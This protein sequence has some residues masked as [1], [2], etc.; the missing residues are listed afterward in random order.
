MSVMV[1]G[2]RGFLG[3]HAVLALAH[4][5]LDVTVGPPRSELNLETAPMPQIVAI[6]RQAGARTIVNA[7]GRVT[8][9]AAELDAGNAGVVRR[10]IEACRELGPGARLVHLGSAAEYGP[11]DE[12]LN[13]TSPPAPVTA[14]GISK[15]E[16]TRHLLEASGRGDVDGVVLRVFNPLG[17]GQPAGTLPGAVAAQLAADLDSDIHVAPLTAWRDFV[18]ARDVGRAIAAAVSADVVQER[19][20]NIASGR[21]TAVRQAIELMRTRAGHRGR[22]VEGPSVPGPG[23]AIPPWSAA[24]ISR[25]ARVLPW[26]PL[27]DLEAAVIDLLRGAGA[28]NAAIAPVC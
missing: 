26:T 7:T 4:A 24:D 3:R 6:L 17:S 18:S 16:A 5:G 25:A 8:G 11:A 21:A 10:L 27:D 22:L 2:S 12:R 19:V 28:G 15:L 14:Y 23:P 20:L 1:L 9:T 13:E